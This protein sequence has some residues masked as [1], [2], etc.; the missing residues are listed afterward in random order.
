MLWS[1]GTTSQYNAS[2]IAQLVSNSYHESV[3]AEIT[4]LESAIAVVRDDLS[5]CKSRYN[6]IKEELK[7]KLYTRN[8][9]LCSQI[10][11]ENV[12]EYEE[13]AEEE[14][15]ARLRFDQQ[16]A[17]LTHQQL[18]LTQSRLVTLRNTSEDEQRKVAELEDRKRTTQVE[19]TEAQE[20][21]TKAAN[22]L[23]QALKEIGLKNDEIEKL[24]LERSATYRKCRLEDIKLPLIIYYKPYRIDDPATLH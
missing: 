11:V 13:F 22:I 20:T 8:S 15:Q 6:G 10:G 18:K 1:V 12:R 7:L 9:L 3:I 2:S 17:R 5:A 23:D 19:I 21:H 24:A 14:S 4:R 16:V